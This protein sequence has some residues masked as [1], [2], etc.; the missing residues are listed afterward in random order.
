MNWDA[1]GAIAEL[2]GALGVIA[3][4]F[5]LAS[6]IRQSNVLARLSENNASMDQISL[7]RMAMAQDEKLAALFLLGAEGYSE[8]PE[9]EKIRFE[10]LLGQRFWTYE[11]LWDRVQSKVIEEEHWVNVCIALRGLFSNRGIDEWWHENKHQFP[12]GFVS[13]VDSL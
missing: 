2:V 1:L 8:L 10:S 11:Q 6:Q 4:L 12:E 5:Y 9:L 7:L 13:D 3:T